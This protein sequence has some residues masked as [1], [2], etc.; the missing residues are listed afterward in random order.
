M[1]GIFALVLTLSL[2][3]ICIFAQEKNY[4][5]SIYADSTLHNPHIPTY[6]GFTFIAGT[7]ATGITT[8]QNLDPS[9]G[10]GFQVGFAKT[11][12]LHSIEADCYADKYFLL[13][14]TN[15]EEKPYFGFL[16]GVEVRDI[17]DAGIGLNYISNFKNKHFIAL[18]P[19]LGILIPPLG[20]FYIETGW[21]IILL[22]P[23]FNLWGHFT[24][25]IR[26]SID[27]LTRQ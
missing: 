13:E 16:T 3:S 21:N 19:T 22:S 9:T 17:I 12:K 5:P 11:T 2:I 25:G 6:S 26:Y 7:Y 18:R 10:V 20:Q 24:F 4:T 14:V 1:R 23:Y 15:F 27:Y 8:H